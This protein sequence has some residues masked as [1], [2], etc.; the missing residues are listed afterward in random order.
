MAHTKRTMKWFLILDTA[1]CISV[2][3]DANDITAEIERTHSGHN[4]KGN[5]K[6]AHSEDYLE[7]EKF[8]KR[9]HTAENFPSPG[10]VS[11]TISC[12]FSSSGTTVEALRTWK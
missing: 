8:R 5:R 3:I 6:L 11:K 12:I 4:L 2:R 10:I 7:I 1:S 9:L